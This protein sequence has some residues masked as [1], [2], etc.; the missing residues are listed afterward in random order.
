MRKYVGHVH[1]WELAYL[2]G[3]GG[4]K[5]VFPVKSYSNEYKPT[6]DVG[7]LLLHGLQHAL[8]AAEDYLDDKQQDMHLH[9]HQD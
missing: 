5:D 3:S 6:L 1:A 8:Y 4:I 7:I 9:M 2:S